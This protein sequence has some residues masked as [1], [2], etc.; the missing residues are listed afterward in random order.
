MGY[1]LGIMNAA[2]TYRLG[3]TVSF[4]GTGTFAFAEET[5]R[6]GGSAMML[7]RVLFGLDLSADGLDVA[8]AHRVRV[9]GALGDRRLLDRIDVGQD[10]ILEGLVDEG[11]VLLIELSYAFAFDALD[12]AL[13]GESFAGLGVHEGGAEHTEHMIAF[14]IDEGALGVGAFSTADVLG[15]V[16]DGFLHSLH[17]SNFVGW[18]N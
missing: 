12:Q 17:C 2:I 15:G 3:L 16:L 6:S 13:L 11:D 10:L 7:E 8:A 4:A 18:F 14:Q 5:F 1:R 9:V